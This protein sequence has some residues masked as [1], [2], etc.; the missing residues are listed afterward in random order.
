MPQARATVRQTRG[1]MNKTTFH[2]AIATLAFALLACVCWVAAGMVSDRMVQQELTTSVRVEQQMA[3][4]IVDNTAQII[5]SDLAMS[6]AIPATIAEMDMIQLALARAKASPADAVMFG[7]T[8]YDAQAALA[9]D[10]TPIGVLSGG[11]SKAAGC[12][13]V[14]SDTAALLKAGLWSRIDAERA[15]AA[16]WA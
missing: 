8:P 2:R 4:S 13:A 15:R 11:F 7:D 5:A 16:P 9:A 14:Y 12:A 6:R 3:A 1:S 10:V